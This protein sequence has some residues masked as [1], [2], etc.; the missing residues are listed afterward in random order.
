MDEGDRRQHNDLLMELKR[1][2]KRQKAMKRL[3]EE[4]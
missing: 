3:D 2:A 4:C 1:V